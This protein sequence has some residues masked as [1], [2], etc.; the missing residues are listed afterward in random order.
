M[1]KHN[2][3][4]LLF[5]LKR[6]EHPYEP[7]CN[8]NEQNQS[9]DGLITGLYN[10]VKFI[11]DML[12]ANNVE[13][14]MVVV[15]DNNDIDR[16]VTKYRPTDVIIEA[17]WVVPE[18]FNILIT[19]HPKVNWI[20]RLHSAFPFIANEGIAMDWIFN[21]FNYSNVAVSCNDLRIYKDLKFLAHKVLNYPES[22][23]SHMFMYQP[24]YYPLIFKEKTF[25]FN[26]PHIDISCFG[27]I[28]PMKNQLAQAIAAIKF[29]K[30]IDK[31]LFFHI[32]GDRIEM[33]GS[34]VLHNLQGLF[35]HVDARS[36]LVTHPWTDHKTF[37]ELCGTMDIGMQVSFTETFNIVMPDHLTLGVPIITSP[38]ILWSSPI[39]QA[40]PNDTS[41]IVDALHMTW[42]VPV[43][44][45]ITNKIHLEKYCIESEKVWLEQYGEKQ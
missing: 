26:K 41:D 35:N 34:P 31:L 7:Y 12:R 14:N 45:V 3:H 28:R 36:R 10:S 42:N 33:K 22:L 44:N 9:G 18:K 24:N 40:D 37:K 1:N 25:D 30:E 11:V 39:F 32:N 15:T 17:L 20:V 2:K 29:A 27:A 13:A 16:E 38:D 21:Y 4:K 6:K 5:I 19:L 8:T 23:L 43:F